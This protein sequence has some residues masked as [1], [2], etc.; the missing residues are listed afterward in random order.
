LTACLKDSLQ[1]DDYSFEGNNRQQH[2]KVQIASYLAKLQRKEMIA[3]L[4]VHRISNNDILSR[5]L[6]KWRLNLPPNYVSKQLE[7]LPGF[8]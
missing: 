4:G 7:V 8:G 2:L 1:Q 6:A 3:V 5:V